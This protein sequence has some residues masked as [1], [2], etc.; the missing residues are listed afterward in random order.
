[1]NKSTKFLATGIA[2]LIGT[3]LIGALAAPANAETKSYSTSALCS[4]AS[5]NM[6]ADSKQAYSRNTAKVQERDRTNPKAGVSLEP[7]YT[8][9]GC[10]KNNNGKYTFTYSPAPR[11]HGA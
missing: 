4:S 10:T 1:M 9:S 7:V 3:G 8:V 5:K 6:A 2:T 11:Q